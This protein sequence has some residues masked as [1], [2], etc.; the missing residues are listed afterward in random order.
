MFVPPSRL[1]C[2][3][4]RA[5]LTLSLA[6]SL[7]VLPAAWAQAQRYDIPAGSLAEAL[8]Q[9]A[10]ASGVMITFSAEDT[11]GLGSPGLQGDFE[12]HQGFAR[13]LQGSGL[14]LVQAGNK[15]YVL[16]K[17][18]RGAALELGAT[19]INAAGLG[20]TT[21]GT[22]SYTTGQSSTATKLPLTL[23]ETPQSISVVTRQRMDDQG[24]ND[25]TEVLQQTPGLSVQS[26]GSERFNIYS[27]GYSVDNYQFD[28]I[29]TTLDIATQMSAQSLADMAIYDRVEVLRGA[30]G[31]MT[32]AGDPSATINLVRKRPTAEFK[33]H[34]TAGVGSWDKYR[35]EVDLS[36]PLTPTGN[37]RGRMVAAY[38]QNNS[39]MDH[40][41]QE[42]QIFYGVLEADLTDTTLL[43]VGADYQKNN[44]QGSSSVAF[45]LFHSNGEQTS[46][47]RSTNSAARWS[48]NPQDA[49]NTFASLEQ[50]LA[51]DW[52]LKASVN[53]MYIKR[54]DYKL[55]TA[56]W[57]FP[58]KSTGAG[59]RLYGGAGSTWQKQTGLDVQAQ[60]PFQLF[61]RQHEL[62]V[63][64][65]YSRYENRHTPTRGTRIEG[66]FVN[67]YD[68]D[69][70]T[71]KPVMGGGKLYDGD[72]VIHQ[73]GTYIAT[74]LRP[75]DDLSVIL[76]ARV[77]K[78]DYDYDLTY[79]ATPLSNR[80][81]DYKENGVVTPYA[82]VV[83]DLNDTHSVYAS[84]TSI[85]K[86]QSLRD[87]DGSTLEPREG[88]NYEVGLK[89][90]FFDGRLNT[91]IAAYEVKQDNLAVLDE[92]KTVNNDGMTAAYK[93]VS[94]ATTRGFEVEANGELMPGWNVS[95]SY[96][97]GITKDRDGE[98]LNTEAPANMVK[99]WSTYRLP[100]DFDRLTVG[101]GANWQSG[102][103]ITVTPSTALGTVK[104]KQSQFTVV[105]LMA[106]Y[107]LTDQLSTTLNINNLFDKKY[108]SA[109]DT[110]FYSGYYGEP[111]NVML[112]TRYDF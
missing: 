32:G 59:V 37:V 47:S 76:G 56:S 100:G 109:L 15:R 20:A 103:H 61:G 81:T 112:N 28:G 85:Y 18:E 94:G 53:Q 97:H 107:Q 7:L 5:A 22:G 39:F 42:K 66:T 41:S 19:S 60:G 111:R 35:S 45:P 84:W 67:V 98:R 93:A 90:E 1:A 31:L 48:H 14:R 78:Y 88:D 9:F 82:G 29:P 57:G 74:R 13:L 110:T 102:T 79:P 11:A 24:L 92:G 38:Q 101:G 26:L 62:I 87:A 54:D 80:T 68:W 21:E 108:I 8:S 72:T 46:F 2:G 34:I 6:G 106:R 73:T 63:G 12:L 27:R 95:A 44:P 51:Y 65:N 30:T 58:D 75:T 99:L 43:T 17:A 40:Y 23:R 83:Y 36:G 64:Y 69:N 55:A 10:A 91:S 4:H 50:K 104:A 33:G 71:D 105:N 3:I 16:A 86:P 96:N 25:I 52:T 77:S 70:Y 89:S 49:L